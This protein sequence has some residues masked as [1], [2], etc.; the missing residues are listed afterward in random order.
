MFARSG[1]CKFPDLEGL[2]RTVLDAIQKRSQGVETRIRD[3][4]GAANLADYPSLRAYIGDLESKFSKLAAHGVRMT[5]SEQ[6]YLLLRGLTA[7][8][9]SIRASIL[10]FRDRSNNRADLATTIAM[11][12]DYEDNVLASTTVTRTLTNDREITLTTINRFSPEGEQC[13]LLFFQTGLL[14]PRRVVSVPTC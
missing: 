8:Y 3:E 14:S 4:I 12:E 5:E 6:R 1:R 10:A 9:N 2:I 11:L 7:D 13:L